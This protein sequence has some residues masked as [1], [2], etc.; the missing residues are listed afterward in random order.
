MGEHSYLPFNI[1]L[2]PNV[3]LSNEIKPDVPANF[4]IKKDGFVKFV[5]I[6]GFLVDIGNPDGW[7]GN[8]IIINN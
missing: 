6:N 5:V 1:L 2:N 7:S 8:S 3:K 4:I